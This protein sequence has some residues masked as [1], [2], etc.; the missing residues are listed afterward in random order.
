MLRY[1]YPTLYALSI[2]AILINFKKIKQSKHLLFFLFFLFYTFLNESFAI[3]RTLILKINSNILYLI[4]NSINFYFFTY[5]VFSGISTKFK[6]YLIY[7]LLLL[8]SIFTIANISYLSP[9]LNYSLVNNIVLAKI[10]TA[11]VIIIY[12][13]ELL[14][15]D[16]ILNIKNSLNFWI[17]L[18]MF[19]YNITFLP[20]FA[21]IVYTSAQ[22][23]FSYI[24]LCLNIVLH[25]C[26]IYGAFI[27]EKK[28]NY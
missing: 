12:F 4:W 22:G 15:S 6:K 26:F 23:I 3:Y 8:F 28:Y 21:L 5:F 24:T 1:V 25:S 13:S 20:A 19:L 2:I 14:K 9:K 17:C 18:A 27:S 11:I 16:A 7:S 10:C